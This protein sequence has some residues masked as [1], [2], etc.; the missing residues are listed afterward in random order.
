MP[1]PSVPLRRVQPP[2]GVNPGCRAVA[3]VRR[4]QRC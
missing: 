2:F 3:Q 4:T 1:R